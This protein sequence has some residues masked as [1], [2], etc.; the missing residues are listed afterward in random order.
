MFTE[1]IKLTVIR[2]NWALVSV[3]DLEEVPKT[4]YLKWRE[5]DGTIYANTK[6]N[7]ISEGGSKNLV[8]AVDILVGLHGTKVY[9]SNKAG[10]EDD[11]NRMFIVTESLI[12]KD[13]IDF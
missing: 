4:G 5:K 13:I 7:E 9:T 6:R 8:T 2:G 12:K 10:S 11:I 3:Q 1:K